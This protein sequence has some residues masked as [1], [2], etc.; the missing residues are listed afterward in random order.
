MYK[1]PSFVLLYIDIQLSHYLLPKKLWKDPLN[2]LGTQSEMID[3][4]LMALFL[5]SQFYSTDLYVSLYASATWSFFKKKYCCCY[6][7]LFRAASA[8]Y[9][10]SWARG[11]I[12]ATAAS[13]HHS[14]SNS[15]SEPCLR[16]TSQLMATLNPRPTD[17]GQGSYQSPHGY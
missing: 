3:H 13:P 4:K 17:R 1:G 11:G 7:S 16:P 9:L 8:A 2:C 14:H 6:Y 5:N 10:I 15:E 12:Q